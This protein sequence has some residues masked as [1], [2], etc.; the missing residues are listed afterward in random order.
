[1]WGEGGE[2]LTGILNLF[3]VVNFKKFLAVISFYYF[4]VCSWS[5]PLCCSSFPP[6]SGLCPET[7]NDD[8]GEGKWKVEK[9][10]PGESGI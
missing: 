7:N 10:K 5:Y 3:L 4:T 9:Q 6:N 1:M 8:I 2:F